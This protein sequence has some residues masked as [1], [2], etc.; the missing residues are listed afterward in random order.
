MKKIVSTVDQYLAE[1][2]VGVRKLHGEQRLQQGGKVLAEI[3][4]LSEIFQI[5]FIEIRG[6]LNLRTKTWEDKNKE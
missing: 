4:E 5:Y 6:L 3:V 2:M 1:E